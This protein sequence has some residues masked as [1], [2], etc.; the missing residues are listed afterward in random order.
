MGDGEPQR[1][2][3]L[4]VGQRLLIVV[5]MVLLGWDRNLASECGEAKGWNTKIR[6]RTFARRRDQRHRS[7]CCWYSEL[8]VRNGPSVSQPASQPAD[9]PPAS[10][11]ASPWTAVFTPHRSRQSV[12]GWTPE[13]K[14]VHPPRSYPLRHVSRSFVPSP[15]VQYLLIFDSLALRQ[16][17]SSFALSPVPPYSRT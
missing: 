3:E 1:E 11:P 7:T 9:S 12:T 16:V 10:Q 17:A 2:G 15:G 13:R 6:P 4:G 8:G 14:H 5:V